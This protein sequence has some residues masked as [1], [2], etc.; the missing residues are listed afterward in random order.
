MTETADGVKARDDS[1]RHPLR[2]PVLHDAGYFG[3]VV[4]SVVT[5]GQP[6]DRATAFTLRR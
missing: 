2:I 6:V 3:V 4:A 1:Q 5:G